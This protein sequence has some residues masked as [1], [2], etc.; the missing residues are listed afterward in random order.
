MTKHTPIL[1]SARITGGVA[2]AQPHDSAHKH[3]RTLHGGL[4]LSTVAHGMIRGIDL[5]AVREALI[6]ASHRSICEDVFIHLK[7]PS[8]IAKWSEN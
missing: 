6:A 3:V 8:M 5:S 7:P 1:T 4:G 2:T